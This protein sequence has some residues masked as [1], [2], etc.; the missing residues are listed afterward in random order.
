MLGYCLDSLLVLVCWSRLL[1]FDW[2]LLW[3]FCEGCLL[4]RCLLITDF[5]VGFDYGVYCFGD[6][7]FIGVVCFRLL[8]VFCYVVGLS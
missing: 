2:C 3:C 7:V 8:F 4:L 1:P 6:L 5:L